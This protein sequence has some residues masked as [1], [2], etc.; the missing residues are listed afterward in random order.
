MTEDRTAVWGDPAVSPQRATAVTG[1]SRPMLRAYWV[2]VYVVGVGLAVRGTQIPGLTGLAAALICG[3]ALAPA[4]FWCAGQTAG[5]PVFPVFAST[6]VWTYALPLLT[7]HEQ[8]MRYEPEDHFAAGLAVSGFLVLATIVWLVLG[9]ARASRPRVLYM[10]AGPRVVPW[11]TVA[12]GVEAAFWTAGWA[13]WFSLDVGDILPIRAALVGVTTVSGLSTI[14]MEPTLVHAG[15]DSRCRC[16]SDRG[17]SR[18]YGRT[19]PDERTVEDRSGCARDDARPTSRPEREHRTPAR[20]GCAI[21]LRQTPDARS[22]LGEC[23]GPRDRNPAT[24]GL[25]W[26]LR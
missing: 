13:G 2:V 14:P 6:F 23:P 7:G 19:A 15:R 22:V 1:A 5:L 4:Y 26:L 18:E 9:R 3:A 10:L 16:A 20:P 24:L 25:P 17:R 12:L 11:L 21:A 8:T